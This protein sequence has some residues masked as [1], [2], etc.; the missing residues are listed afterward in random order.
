[1]LVRIFLILCLLSLNTFSQFVGTNL[2]YANPTYQFSFE[3]DTEKI[4]MEPNPISEVSLMFLGPSYAFGLQFSDEKSEDKEFLESGYSDFLITYYAQGFVVDLFYREFKDFYVLGDLEE[5]TPS[6]KQTIAGSELGVQVL[7]MQD[8]N[9]F[10]FHGDY[11]FSPKTTYDYFVKLRLSHSELSGEGQI[12]PLKY[13]EDFS[14]ISQYEK[15]LVDSIEA[16]LGLSG[17]YAFD[18][19]Y[20]NSYFS[21]GPS[22]EGHLVE[23]GQGKNLTL[24]S[25]VVEAFLGISYYLNSFQFGMRSQGRYKESDLNGIKHTQTYL[26]NYAYLLLFF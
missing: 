9:I 15:W 22:L 20:I 3:S 12:I 19:I 24:V 18:K 16:Q 25:P 17:L 8:Q 4:I 13:A 14:K 1:M 21:L 23:G 7:F 6:N 10:E 5:Q 11:V 2:K 26:S